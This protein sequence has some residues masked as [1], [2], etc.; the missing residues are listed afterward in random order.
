MPVSCILPRM[1][2]DLDLELD[3]SYTFTHL[4]PQQARRRSRG[5]SFSTMPTGPW[6][7]RS[8]GRGWRGGT[9]RRRRVSVFFVLLIFGFLIYDWVDVVGALVG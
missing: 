5:A 8:G 4:P 6:A 1:C 3:L 9:R 7:A 2:T